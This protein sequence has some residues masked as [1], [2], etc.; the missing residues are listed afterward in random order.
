MERG[1][2]EL[3]G[4]T[5]DELLPREHLAR[6]VW[7]VIERLDLSALYARIQARGSNAGASAVDPRITLCLWVYAM[8]DG[9]GSSHEVS[10]LCESDAAYRWMRGGVSVRQRHLSNFRARSGELFLE[11]STQIVAVLL[12]LGLCDLVRVAQ[13]GTRVRASAGAASFRREETLLKLRDEAKAHL[14][15]VLEDADDPSLTRVRRAAR[16]RGAREKLERIE[17][18][19]RE[20]PKAAATKK[21]EPAKEPRVSTTDPEARVMKMGDGGFRPAYNVQFATTCDDARVIAGVTVTNSGT[22]NAEAVPMVAELDRRYDLKPAELLVDGGYAGHD[23]LEKLAPDTVVYAPLKKARPDQR[24]QAEPRSTDSDVVAEWR[25][26]MQTDDA[27]ETYKER[28]ATAETVNADAKTHRALDHVPI[29]GLHKAL[30]LA[31]LFALSYN[32]LRV[33]SLAHRGA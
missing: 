12:K 27:K 3:I 25:R 26:R 20:L 6:D 7:R 29:R 11:L 21:K 17:A 16:E 5:L 13:D 9:E 22:D 8:L 23:T 18:A 15:K 24:P 33:V 1:Q 14:E 2:R 28:A 31:G 19:L 32:I 4:R 30:G 10:R